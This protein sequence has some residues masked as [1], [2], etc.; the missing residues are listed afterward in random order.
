MEEIKKVMDLIFKIDDQKTL[1]E[2]NKRLVRHAK[3][4][5]DRKTYA[6]AMNFMVGDLVQFKGRRGNILKG[7]IQKMNIKRAKVMVDK[8]FP[9]VWN[10][11]FSSLEKI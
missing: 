9:Q 1:S 8:P 7:I 6:S 4:V 11:Y 3:Q 10:V 2:I 5:R